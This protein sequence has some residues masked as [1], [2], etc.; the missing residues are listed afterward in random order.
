[1]TPKEGPKSQAW[2]LGGP[3]KTLHIFAATSLPYFQSTPSVWMEHL[4]LD[5]FNSGRQEPEN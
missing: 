2:L 1:M 5:N 4:D 3:T